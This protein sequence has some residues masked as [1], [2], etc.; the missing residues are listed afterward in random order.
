MIGRKE[1]ASFLG[2]FG[3]F[4]CPEPLNTFLSPGGQAAIWL[5]WAGSALPMDVAVKS[6]RPPPDK[7]LTRTDPSGMDG[8][9]AE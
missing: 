6:M 2:G 1:K 3:I 8:R 5:P 4:F 7:S 9:K